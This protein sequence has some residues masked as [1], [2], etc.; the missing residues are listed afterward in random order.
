MKR[1]IRR[2]TLGK[3]R[4]REEGTIRYLVTT[5]TFEG[6]QEQ[7][8]ERPTFVLDMLVRHVAQQRME[9][10]RRVPLSMFSTS[11][12]EEY[13]YRVWGELSVAIGT[14]LFQIMVATHLT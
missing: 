5:Q 13:T 7:F 1:Q 14:D 3:R 11:L 10:E 2:N 12:H 4:V 9:Q 8:S 6:L